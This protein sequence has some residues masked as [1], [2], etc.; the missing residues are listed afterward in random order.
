MASWGVPGTPS[1]LPRQANWE[2]GPHTQPPTKSYRISQ[3][4][5]TAMHTHSHTTYRQYHHPTQPQATPRLRPHN[6]A[7]SAYTPHVLQVTDYDPIGNPGLVSTPPQILV[8]FSRPSKGLAERSHREASRGTLPKPLETSPSLLPNPVFCRPIHPP[9]GFSRANGGKAGE[10]PL[11]TGSPQDREKHRAPG[12]V[13]RARPYSHSPRASTQP[14]A[15]NNPDHIR[16]APAPST[17]PEPRR[18]ERAATSYRETPD[19][20]LSARGC[21]VRPGSLHNQPGLQQPW[22]WGG[23]EGGTRWEHRLPP[24][25]A[26]PGLAALLLHHRP[27]RYPSPHHR[28][29]HGTPS[30]AHL[31]PTRAAPGSPRLRKDNW[32]WA[33]LRTWSGAQVDPMKELG[34]RREGVGSPCPGSPGSH[35]GLLV[36]AS[37]IFWALGRPVRSR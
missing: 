35:V 11:G 23:A 32:V 12:H 25:G 3:C 9:C 7:Q 19:S 26:T 15:S 29:R 16:T 10:R 21:R 37:R 33:V 4:S 27:P 1:P 34:R 8:G 31:R 13:Y 5:H 30:P 22:G 2:R 20:P 14:D 36:L 24:T 6:Y 17:Q 18:G 28:P